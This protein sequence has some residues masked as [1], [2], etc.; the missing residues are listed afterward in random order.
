MSKGGKREGAGRK[1]TDGKRKGY[2]REL[3]I[4]L[5]EHEFVKDNTTRAI[6]EGLKMF[7]A[8]KES[9]KQTPEKK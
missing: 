2:Y 5:I 3:P 8:H 6:I 4:S 7:I 9:L 1:P